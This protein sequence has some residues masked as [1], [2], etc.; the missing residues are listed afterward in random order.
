MSNYDASG[1][2]EYNL[3]LSERRA[4]AVTQYLSSKHGVDRGKLVWAGEG[5][6]ELRNANLPL[7]A[8]NRRVELNIMSR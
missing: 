4:L 5:E 7:D 1:S 2:E 8:S 6:R 3:V